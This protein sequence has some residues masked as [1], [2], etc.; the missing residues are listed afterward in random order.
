MAPAPESGMGGKRFYAM[1]TT[2]NSKGAFHLPEREEKKFGLLEESCTWVAQNPE[3]AILADSG[4]LIK[5]L[6]PGTDSNR[7]SITAEGF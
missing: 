6:V 4:F 5:S 2:Q 1:L 3:P 7:H